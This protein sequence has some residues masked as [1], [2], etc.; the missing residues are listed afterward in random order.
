MFAHEL[1]DGKGGIARS[2]SKRHELDAI[3]NALRF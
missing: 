1:G 2:P 3:E